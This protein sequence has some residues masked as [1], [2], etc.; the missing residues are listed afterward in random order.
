MKFREGKEKNIQWTYRL[1]DPV[2]ECTFEREI[3]PRI[4]F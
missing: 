4:K 2:Q 3:S 1:P